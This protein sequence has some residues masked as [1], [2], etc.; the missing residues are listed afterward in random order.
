MVLELKLELEEYSERAEHINSEP[1][2]GNRT[3]DS[4]ALTFFILGSFALKPLCKVFLKVRKR[5]PPSVAM[6]SFKTGISGVQ[7]PPSRLRDGGETYSSRKHGV[8]RFRSQL[9]L[10]QTGNAE[11]LLTDKH[12]SVEIGSTFVLNLRAVPIHPADRR[13][14]A[15]PKLMFIA[16]AVLI[17]ILLQALGAAGAIYAA[18]RGNSSENETIALAV[19]NLVTAM[20]MFAR[21]ISLRGTRVLT[22]ITWWSQAH[23][24]FSPVVFFAIVKGGKGRV[25]QN[26]PEHI[27][28]LV[29][30]TAEE[31]GGVGFGDGK[32]G[33]LICSQ[34]F[35]RASQAFTKSTR[36]APGQPT[37][38]L[39][40]TAQMEKDR[41]THCSYPHSVTYTI[42]HHYQ[43]DG[44]HPR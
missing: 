16:S 42:T 35:R 36:S 39:K 37:T 8:L 19:F 13:R 9:I 25:C 10:L 38:A 5:G 3:S 30:R 24:L 2:C 33:P 44:H 26:Y 23:S 15:P 11:P 28:S 7:V 43:L 22:E 41:S 40:G 4:E 29:R 14:P 1:A 6:A 20:G 12:P 17:A 21:C 31:S 27:P 34:S 32:G 18:S